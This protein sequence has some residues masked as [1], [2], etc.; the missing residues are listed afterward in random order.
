MSQSPI[1]TSSQD[2]IDRYLDNWNALAGMISRVTS[3]S[4]RERNCCFLNTRNGRFADVSAATG[5]DLIDDGRGL[6]VVDWDH[7]GDLDVWISNRTGP[8]VRFMRNDIDTENHFLAVRLEGT[9]SN[10]DCI[11]ARLE[12]HLSASPS[13]KRIK[14]VRA[15]EGFLSQ[16]SKWVHF[17]LGKAT[18]IDR[19]VVRWPGSREGT[20]FTGLKAD[21]RYKI[22]QGSGQAIV[23]APRSSRINL[24]ASIAKAA[25][26]TDRSRT[27]LTQRSRLP[28]LDYRDF[29][30]ERHTVGIDNAGPLLVNLWA[31]WCG[32]CLRE[33]DELARHERQLRESGLTVVALCTDT[34]GPDR[35]QDLSAAR[36]FLQRSRLPFQIGVASEGTIRELTSLHNAIFYRQRPLPLPC[37]F[38]VDR[39]GMVMAIYKGPVSADQLLADLRLLDAKQAEIE[40]AAFPFPGRRVVRTYNP[41]PLAFAQA[42]RE[43][44][45]LDDAKAEVVRYVESVSSLAESPSLTE[46]LRRALGPALTHERN[47]T[48]ATGKH[49]VTTA[50]PLPNPAAEAAARDGK[51]ADHSTGKVRLERVLR[52]HQRRTMIQAYQ[53]LAEIER[54]RKDVSGEV[55]ALHQLVR[56]QPKSPSAH[57]ELSIAQWR[58]GKRDDAERRFETALQLTPENPKTITLLGQAYM[59]LGKIQAALDRFR[60]AVRLAPENI[61]VR[62][63]LAMGLQ[64]AGET[65]EAVTQYRQ[66]LLKNADSVQVANNLAWLYATH[67]RAEFR[68]AA[69]ALTLATRICELTNYEAPAY[70]DTLA[71]AQAEAGRFSEAI[72]SI[73]KAI[74]LANG[75][76][77]H[78]LATKLKN[79]I[80]LYRS[81]KPFRE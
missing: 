8:R 52:A 37:S 32:P 40:K 67:P 1:G 39:N 31:S 55:E 24:Q 28:T 25:T 7:D 66:I 43:G 56:L 63:N 26:S 4:G 41:S 13:Q 19:L 80:H 69:E 49:S 12:L 33:L 59:K 36:A 62:F 48:Q 6:A 51:T 57:I 79:R 44:G 45:Y 65:Q 54:E 18:Q 73:T 15:G 77:Q 30:D 72:D 5:L 23:V 68:N 35:T 47:M 3:F 9:T 74:R 10:R 2:S 29:D 70:L 71:A 76:G 53:L 22:V 46:I 75:T 14:T 42:Y 11:G 64:L 34:L 21:R 16:S 81:N 60:Q 27:L 17:G 20:T 61:E 58:Q 38:L 50:D 78:A